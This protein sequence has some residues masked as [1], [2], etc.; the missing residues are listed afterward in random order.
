MSLYTVRQTLE[1]CGVCALS[2]CF[3]PPFPPFPQIST[4]EGRSSACHPQY[5]FACRR[6]VYTRFPPQRM[7]VAVSW[8]FAL[9]REV[10]YT[11]ALYPSRV[12]YGY[13]RSFQLNHSRRGM[14]LQKNTHTQKHFRCDSAW[15]FH[16]KRGRWCRKAL[17]DVL[18]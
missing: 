1:V 10:L 7:C 18:L 8:L 11:A 14:Y 3:S 17:V 13:V 4:R 5:L 15:C 9:E 12:R 6:P 2:F 16:K